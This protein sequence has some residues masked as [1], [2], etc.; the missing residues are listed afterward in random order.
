[1]K[2]N[3]VHVDD[4]TEDGGILEGGGSFLNSYGETKMARSTLQS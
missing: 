4:L 1:M 3:T 2:Q